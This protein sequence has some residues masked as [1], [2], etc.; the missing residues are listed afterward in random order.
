[1]LKYFRF[2]CMIIY[3]TNQKNS[4]KTIKKQIALRNNTS[5]QAIKKVHEKWNNIGMECF[6]GG[7]NDGYL[8]W[9]RRKKPAWTRKQKFRLLR[10]SC[11]LFYTVKFSFKIQYTNLNMNILWSGQSENAEKK[12]N[13]NN[14]KKHSNKKWAQPTRANDNS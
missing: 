5:R 3:F 12:P 11:G 1:M 9:K 7:R 4:M 2:Y 6:E 13:H 10:N 14:K 8:H